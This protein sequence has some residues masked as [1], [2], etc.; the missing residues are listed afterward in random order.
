[1]SRYNDD[2][3]ILDTDKA[4]RSWGET[5]YWD[6]S[7]HI[8]RA[9]GSQWEHETLYLSR[10]GNYWVEHV[11]QWQG[12]TPKGAIVSKQEAAEWLLK[13]N[14]NLPKDLKDY[15]EQISE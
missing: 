9:T 5:T 4:A 14:Y 2:G 15:E 11:S 1:M 3:R 10:K 7:N 6:G 12:S 8:S 13:N